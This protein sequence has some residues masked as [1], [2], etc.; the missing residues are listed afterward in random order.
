LSLVRRLPDEV[1]DQI[2]AGE[3][4]ERPASVVKELVENALDA[5]AHRVVVEIE[6]GGRGRIRV[7][8]DGSGMSRED[9]VLALERHATSKLRQVDDLR[10]IAT[11]GFR[12][13]A[14]PAIASVSHLWLRTRADDA[15]GGT[16]VEVDHG[17]ARGVRD[18]GHPRGTT[19]EVA[20]LFAS[21][22]VRRKF[23]RTEA[24]EA[25]HVAEMATL[26][27][28]PRPEVGFSLRAGERTSLDAPAVQDLE[29]RVYQLFGDAFLDGL[30]PVE[31]ELDWVR[32]RGYV[33]R[34]ER[35][36]GRR[37]VLRLFVNERPIRDRGLARAV[38]EGYRAAGLGDRRPDG[39]ILLDVPSDL[40]DVNVHP[41]KS[42]VRFADARTVWVALERAVREG[43]SREARRQ[44]PVADLSR[45]EEAVSSY[46][47]SP[48]AAAGPSATREPP[49]GG[50]V[51]AEDADRPGAPP[52][53]EEAGGERETVVLGQHRRTYIVVSDGEDLL[54]VD[55]H[56]A[57]ER[58]RFEGLMR[59]AEEHRVP[60]Q[61]LLAPV[62]VSLPPRL[63]PVAEENAAE[64]AALGFDGEPFGGDA[65]RI[66]AVPELLGTRDPGPA[67]VQ[68]LEELLERESSEWAV[69]T[70]RERLAATLACHSAVRGGQ[71]LGPGQMEAI[72]RDLERAEH[73]SLCPHG[74][75]TRVRLPRSEVSRWFGRSGWRRQ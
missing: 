2:K 53:A 40:V 17:R 41:T 26:M 12:G 49:G 7:R 67:V 34:P 39:L 36:S 62:V 48:G 38:A 60:S 50:A 15:E 22:P 44:A 29:S 28:L 66:R 24:T 33:A 69:A 61:G 58:V 19:V 64:L 6:G 57:H 75:P 55:Q 3:V 32:L 72:V 46:L 30:V 63:R 1:V 65:L 74:R 51:A 71:L 42:E 45:V 35:A 16:E 8:D 9:A 56:T 47:S 14:L 59:G 23:L 20:D 31:G 21:V 18:V 37:P 68:L 4:V 52:R 70:A 43:V 73:P 5:G 54:L 11:R 13:E 27:A 10:S 25:A